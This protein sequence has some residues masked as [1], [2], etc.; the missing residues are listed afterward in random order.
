MNPAPPHARIRIVEDKEIY[1]I[2]ERLAR[3]EE[4]YKAQEKAQVVIAVS[5][6]DYK[7]IANEWRGTVSD[8]GSKCITRLE[9]QAVFDRMN[10]KLQALEKARN[11]SIGKSSGLSASWGVIVALCTLGLIAVGAIVSVAGLLLR[12]R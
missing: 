11:E 3:L 9:A 5:L 10:D 8:V 12:G 4:Q 2:S 1:A 7:A 6:A